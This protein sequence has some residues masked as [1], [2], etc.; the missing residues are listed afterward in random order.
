VANIVREVTDD[1][2][3]A[4]DERKR[5]QVGHAADLS[6]KAKLVKL[7]DKPRTTLGAAETAGG[8]M[9]WGVARLDA[10]LRKGLSRVPSPS[11]DRRLPP[12]HPALSTDSSY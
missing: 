8:A 4:K 1:K 5:L 2:A 7:V 6:R 3:L 10:W 11:H 9:V 12:S